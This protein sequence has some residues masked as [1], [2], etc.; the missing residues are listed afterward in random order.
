MTAFAVCAIR[1]DMT[2]EQIEAILD[3]VRTWPADRQEEAIG[4]L[5]A[6]EAETEGVYVL[7]TEERADLEESLAEMDRGEVASQSEVNAAFR[8]SR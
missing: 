3:R 1:V 6:M 8:R 4:L 7:A 2:K 5:L